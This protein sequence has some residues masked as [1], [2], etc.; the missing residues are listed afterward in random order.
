MCSVTV[1]LQQGKFRHVFFL[2]HSAWNL[3]NQ[4]VCI[5]EQKLGLGRMALNLGNSDCLYNWTETW[6]GQNGLK[7]GKIKWEFWSETPAH[8]LKLSLCCRKGHDAGDHPP[9]TPMRC[10]R[11]SE[12][13]GDNWRLYD[14]ITRHF[15]ATVRPG[16]GGPQMQ[17]S[18]FSRWKGDWVCHG[19][20]LF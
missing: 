8:T 4:M 9:I 7:F 10:A 2:C 17:K 14:Y 20:P 19:F 12:L 5:I 3:R 11:Q 16:S 6:F 13:D 15:I 18:G 1:V